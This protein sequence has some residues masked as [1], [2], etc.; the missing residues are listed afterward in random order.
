MVKVVESIVKFDLCIGCGICV[1]LCPENNLDIQSNVFGEYNPYYK[2]ECSTDCGLCYRVCPFGNDN[3]NE[4]KIGK[5]RFGVGSKV[6]HDPSTGYFLESFVGSVESE[7]KR[8]RSASGGLATWLLTKLLSKGQIDAAFCV[9]PS[10]E[11][12]TLFKYS[13][14]KDIDSIES[15]SGSAYYPVHLSDVL[16]YIMRTPGR[17]AITSLPCFAKGIRLAQMKNKILRERIVSIIG[18]TCGQMKSKH[19]TDYLAALSG[20]SGKLLKVNYR[21]KDKS[22][23]SSNYF[24]SCENG[25]GHRGII[26]WNEGVSEVWNNR[27]FTLNPCNYC[28]DIFS[29][30]ADIVCMD[31]WLPEYISDWRGT[32]LILIRSSLMLEIVMGGIDEGE[33]IA[34]LAP[35]NKIKQ[36]QSGQIVFKRRDIRVRLLLAEKAGIKVPVKRVRANIEFNPMILAKTMLLKQIEKISKVTFLEKVNGKP[37]DLPSIQEDMMPYQKKMHLLEKGAAICHIPYSVLGRLKGEK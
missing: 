3:P 23:P 19:Y 7:A 2:H 29:E 32:S 13:V 18:I 25:K 33:V 5:E 4:D 17:Y 31:A 9:V 28:D 15:S 12:D 1:S 20:V 22:H 8:K 21:G 30:C 11:P 16:S 26:F 35:I 37:N 27:W 10:N 6:R 24:F 14:L 36:S 34:A